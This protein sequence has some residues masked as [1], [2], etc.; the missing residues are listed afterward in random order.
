M[1]DTLK[2]LQELKEEIDDVMTFKDS[3]LYHIIMDIIDRKI[4]EVKKR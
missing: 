3:F 4:R 2:V 1:E